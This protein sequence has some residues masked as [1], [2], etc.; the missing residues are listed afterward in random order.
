MS[1]SLIGML[2]SVALGFAAAGA[3]VGGSNTPQGRRPM[4]DQGTR[5]Q[6]AGTTPDPD[7]RH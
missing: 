7:S 5:A 6:L 2:V 3:A 1:P 4:I